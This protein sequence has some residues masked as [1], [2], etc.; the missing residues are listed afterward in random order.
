VDSLAYAEYR[1]SLGLGNKRELVEAREAAA[2]KPPVLFDQFLLEAV[3]ISERE[4]VILAEAIELLA[5][6]KPGLY[7]RY[8]CRLFGRDSV[9]AVQSK[10]PAV[11]GKGRSA[12]EQRVQIVASQRG[13]KEMDAITAVAREQPDLYESYRNNL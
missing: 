5:H 2:A 10:R 12:F 8:R 1:A 7:D 6:R 11:F 9:E 3:E 13:L 4:D